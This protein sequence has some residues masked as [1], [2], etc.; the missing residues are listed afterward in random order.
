MLEVEC[1]GQRGNKATGSGRNGIAKRS[2]APLHKHSLGGCKI[3]MPS[4][5]AIGE[6]HIVS[7]RHALFRFGNTLWQCTTTEQACKSCT[8]TLYSFL[9]L[10]FSLNK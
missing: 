2:L 8:C 1:T 3:N 10:T 5:T 9:S 4:R 6:K 7:P